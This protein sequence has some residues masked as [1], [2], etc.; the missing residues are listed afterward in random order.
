MSSSMGGG[1]REAGIW[2]GEGHLD[3]SPDGVEVG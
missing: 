2:S 1:K 3:I